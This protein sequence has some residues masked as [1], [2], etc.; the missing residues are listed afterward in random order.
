MNTSDQ[1]VF[2]LDTAFQRRWEMRMIENN[3]DK[4]DA[5]FANH[6]ILDTTVTWKTFCT[7]INKIILDKKCKNDII[8][9]KRLGYTLSI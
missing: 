6:P 7:E 3:F 8:E 2:T 1:N 5:E 4:A 9:D